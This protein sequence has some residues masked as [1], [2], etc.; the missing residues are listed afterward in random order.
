MKVVTEYLT[1]S[2]RGNTDI[3]DITDDIGEK[4]KSTKLN[5]GI[6]TISIC[7]STAA[8]TTC[9]YEPALVKDLGD[10]FEKLI[11]KNRQYAH[12]QTWG[13]ANGFSHLRASLVGP[14][15]TIPFTNSSLMLG[16]WQQIIFIDFD[17]RARRRKVI[18]Q[19]MGE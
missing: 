10:I 15:I 16:T 9:E 7:G 12:D 18:L 14:S 17:N 5:S 1:F 11:P 2:T 6:V 13:D 8:I 19:F 4:L 3:V